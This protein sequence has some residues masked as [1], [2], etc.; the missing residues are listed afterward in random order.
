MLFNSTVF[1]P[2]PERV[3]AL[4]LRDRLLNR[5]TR[6]DLSASG[7]YRNTGPATISRDGTTVFFAVPGG[8]VFKDVVTGSEVQ[9]PLP[10]SNWYPNQPSLSDSGATA[11]FVS[12]DQRSSQAYAID[13]STGKLEPISVNDVGEPGNAP[14]IGVGMSGDGRVVAFSSAATNLV[15]GEA[16]TNDREDLFFRYVTTV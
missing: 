1:L 13:R 12:V 10:G 8:A 5:T 6:L 14:A 7:G 16:D 2:G 11:A 9:W 4:L 15:E 3:G